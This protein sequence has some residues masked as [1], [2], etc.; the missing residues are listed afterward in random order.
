MY[1]CHILLESVPLVEFLKGY[2]VQAWL[3]VCE[4]P[5]QCPKKED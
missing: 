3:S 2:T 4:K 1:T 5:W